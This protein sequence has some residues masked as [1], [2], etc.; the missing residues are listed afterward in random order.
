MNIDQD[1][2]FEISSLTT[3][4]VDFTVLRDGQKVELNDVQFDTREY[5]GPAHY[6]AGF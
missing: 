2:I 6:H 1:I 3:D 5:E 4:T